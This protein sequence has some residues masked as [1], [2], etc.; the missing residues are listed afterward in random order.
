[1]KKVRTSL[2]RRSRSK[3][4]QGVVS[5]SPNN[6]QAGGAKS[7]CSG[8]G[9]VPLVQRQVYEAGDRCLCRGD[10]YMCSR[11]LLGVTPLEELVEKHKGNHV[12]GDT[13]LV[14]LNVEQHVVPNYLLKH[15]LWS[16]GWFS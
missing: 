12:S 1:M 5:H 9:F 16:P 3:R 6:R 11:S 13:L 4:M 14:T 10:G 7:W 15:V 2:V 8:V